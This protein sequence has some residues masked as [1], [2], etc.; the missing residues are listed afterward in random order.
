M[1]LK[2]MCDKQLEFSSF[3]FPTKLFSTHIYYHKNGFQ[4]RLDGWFG[5]IRAKKD[6]NCKLKSKYQFGEKWKDAA[7]IAFNYWNRKQN[8]WLLDKS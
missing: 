1:V 6:I 3:C 2:A 8:S 7:H 5:C 4:I